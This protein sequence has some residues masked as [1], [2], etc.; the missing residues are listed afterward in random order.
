MLEGLSTISS[1]LYLWWLAGWLACLLAGWLAGWLA[2]LLACL[3]PCSVAQL[4]A[5]FLAW[6]ACLLAGLLACLACLP[7]CLACLLACFPA[8]FIVKGWSGKNK[9][10]GRG[11]NTQEKWCALES[12]AIMWGLWKWILGSFQILY[13]QYIYIMVELNCIIGILLFPPWGN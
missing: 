10:R 8:G 13:I 9:S 2:R 3:L 12:F 1:K 11:K 4:F 5:C 7:A 6:L